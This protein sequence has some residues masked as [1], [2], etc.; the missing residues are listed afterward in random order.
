MR[1]LQ[2]LRSGGEAPAVGLRELRF[3]GLGV[4]GLGFRVYI[5]FRV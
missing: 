2:P 4:Q 1:V 5:G 3:A